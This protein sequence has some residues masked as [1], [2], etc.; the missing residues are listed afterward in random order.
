M[1]AGYAG[2][3]GDLVELHPQGIEAQAD[4]DD[5]RSPESYLGY[6][7]ITNYVGRNPVPNRYAQYTFPGSLPVNTLSY[8]GSWKIGA[9]AITAGA[10]AR[11]GLHFEASNVYIVM[12]GHGTVQAFVDGKPERTLKLKF[13]AY[14]VAFLPDGKAIVTGHDNHICY[15]TPLTLPPR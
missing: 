10:A 11:L 15:I 13:G 2:I 12:G 9:E 4:W 3:G 5:V 8:D 1:Q 14:C 6:A 7:R